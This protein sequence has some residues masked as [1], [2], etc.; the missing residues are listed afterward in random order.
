LTLEPLNGIKTL[1]TE[2]GEGGAEQLFELYHMMFYP[3]FKFI[4]FEFKISFVVVTFILFE[5][6]H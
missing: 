2:E 1:C 5:H 4:V 3:R 6:S